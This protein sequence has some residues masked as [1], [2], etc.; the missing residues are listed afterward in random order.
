MCVWLGVRVRKRD[1][2]EPVERRDLLLHTTNTTVAAD[3]KHMF[4]GITLLLSGS[5]ADAPRRAR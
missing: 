3:L 1:K 5:R 4:D 2:K